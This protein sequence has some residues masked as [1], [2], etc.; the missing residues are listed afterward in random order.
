L[1]QALL[2]RGALA[3]IA[4]VD[5]AFSY[6]FQDVMG[7]PQTQLIRTPIENVM[8]G[9]PVGL[10]ADPLSL[11]WGSLAA[12]LGQ[13]QGGNLPGMRQPP[14]PVIANLLVARDDARNYVVLGD[15]FARLNMDAMK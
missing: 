2:S 4:H 11:Q 1:P 6:A 8:K 15:P 12:I 14:S 7:T 3:V 5:R 13:A 10:A 9:Q